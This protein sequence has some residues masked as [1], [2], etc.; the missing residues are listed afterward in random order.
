MTDIEKKVIELLQEDARFSADKI[1]RMVGSDAGTIT[2]V[3]K[4]LEN[5]GI[6]VKYSAV[7][8]NVKM[9]EEVVDALIEVKVTPKA[10][11]GFDA[12]AEQILDFAEV[13]DVYL[14]SGSYDFVVT[15][16][17]KTLR[18]VAMFVSEKLSAIDDVISTATHFILKQYKQ[19]GVIL[20]KG[21]SAKRI[22]VHV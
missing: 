12:L 14:L 2:N 7:I 17:G 1:A 5:R 21:E 8:N 4:S 22:A 15:L 19:G 11:R 20:N 9:D 6:I 3:I 18:D 16:E 13:K 10:N